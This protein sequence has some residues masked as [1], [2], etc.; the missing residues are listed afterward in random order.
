MGT[1]VLAQ[2]AVPM[3]LQ[4][5]AVPAGVVDPREFFRRTQRNVVPLQST[6]YAGLGNSEPSTKMLETGI[7]AGI[8]LKFAGTLTLTPGTG[9]IAS[10]ARWPYG[11]A[12]NTKVMANGQSNL[13]NVNGIQL[14]A[15]EIMQRGDLSDRGVVQAIGGAS[16]GTSRSQGTMALASESWGVGS[17]VTGLGAGTYDVALEWF[18]P[19]AFDQVSLLGAIFA[20]TS[21]TDLNVPVD[22]APLTDLFTLTGNAAAA[23]TGSIVK[24]QI[25]YSIPEGDGGVIIVPDLSS[26]HQL[27][28]SRQP[29]L[30]TGENELR[31]A[32]QGVGRQLE[33]LYWQVYNGAGAGVPLPVNNTNFGQIAL[34]YGGNETPEIWTDAMAL[35]HHNERTFNSDLGA[36]WG[37][38]CL[39]FCSEHALR[40]SIDMG[41]ASELRFKFDI[42]SGVSLTSAACEYVQESMIAAPA[43]G[44]AAAA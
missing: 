40:D 32:G 38:S 19:I 31:L 17:N 21:A 16:P 41:A 3:K 14:K 23:L 2:R 44:A 30:G 35:R 9:T 29:A 6:S 26:F 28:A 24:E 13:I 33:R 12:R 18:Y 42:P 37:F 27:I 5:Q 39:D 8:T 20:Q 36:F 7:V 11:L 15:R 22:W 43:L 25:L 34:R 1:P 10:T 4:G